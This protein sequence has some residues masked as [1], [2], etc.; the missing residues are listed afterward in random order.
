[1][2]RDDG[3]TRDLVDQM[4]LRGVHVRVVLGAVEQHVVTVDDML[5][6]LAVV[7]PRLQDELRALRCR[8]FDEL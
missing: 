8:L 1:M 5:A 4:A 3:S 2:L 7:V 6:N